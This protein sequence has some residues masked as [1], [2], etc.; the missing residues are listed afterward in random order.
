MGPGSTVTAANHHSSEQ[1][2]PAGKEESWGESE[3]QHS[4]AAQRPGELLH[5]VRGGLQEGHGRSAKERSEQEEEGQE[6]GE[7]RGG[8]L[9]RPKS[10]IKNH[11]HREP[12]SSRK[13]HKRISGTHHRHSP[14][15]LRRMEAVSVSKTSSSCKLMAHDALRSVLQACALSQL[16]F[17]SQQCIAQLESIS[18]IF[19]SCAVC[20]LY[21]DLWFA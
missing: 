19:L 7:E 6:E 21:R 11:I 8:C 15:R 1:C 14:H 2:S 10:S 5:K 16:A 4:G 20:V 9:R 18:S 17:L 12:G 3:D 13:T